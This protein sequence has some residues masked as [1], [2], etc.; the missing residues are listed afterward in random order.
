MRIA[1]RATCIA[2]SLRTCG[3]FIGSHNASS[4][5]LS[6]SSTYKVVT[7]NPKRD[8]NLLVVAIHF[9]CSSASNRLK[10]VL[11]CIVGFEETER[12][13]HERSDK[14]RFRGPRKAFERE[15]NQAAVL[16]MLLPHII[17]LIVSP[18]TRT[19][20]FVHTIAIIITGRVAAYKRATLALAAAHNDQVSF[21]SVCYYAADVFQ[22][23]KELNSPCLYSHAL[24][25]L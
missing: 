19:S 17:S 2:L 18:R 11:D 15:Q 23:Q 6:S 20:S 21:R 3:R 1:T 7:Q 8:G 9:Q 16:I 13:H 25:S 12:R 5:S 24:S 22:S 10:N 14:A 4:S